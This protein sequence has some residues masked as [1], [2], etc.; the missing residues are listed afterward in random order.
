MKRYSLL[1]VALIWIGPFLAACAG[2]GDEKTTLAGI[3]SDSNS[4]L[5]GIKVGVE[6]SFPPYVN[7]NARNKL[8]GFDIDLMKAIAK[9]TGMD[10][11]FYN[12][13][14]DQLLAGVSQCKLD[15]GISALPITGEY[16]LYLLFSDPYTTVRSA[17]V[18]KKGNL[19][20][21][22][23]DRLKGTTIG[24][25]AGFPGEEEVLKIP[26][27][28]LIPYSTTGLAIQDLVLGYLEA[29]ITDLPHA[30]SYVKIKGNNLKLAGDGFT[31]VD[32]G[33]AICKQ[34]PDLAAKINAGIAAVK[35]NGTL[36]KLAEKW[37]LE[38]DQ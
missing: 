35:A 18:V 8:T 20:I 23:R 28:K 2:L 38:N 31:P 6:A 5:S 19:S 33:I 32:Y 17:V 37:G 10:I 15:L 34:R 29:V 22:G 13:E 25:T 4:E 36:D 14:T 16:N 24:A 9:E 27:A 11:T 7:L 30:L 3:L 26:D 21:T 12:V 1:I